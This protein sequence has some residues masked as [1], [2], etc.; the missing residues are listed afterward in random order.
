MK[1]MKELY[2][3][4]IEAEVFPAMG[5]TEPIAVALAAATACEGFGEEPLSVGITLNV[6][7]Y[8]NGLAVKI[9]NTDNERGNL[10][11]AVL[12]AFIGSAADK[13][14][15]LKNVTP[16]ILCK[17]KQFLKQKKGSVT[18][19]SEKTDFYVKAEII[20][21]GHMGT[22]I[23]EHGHT[24]VSFLRQD[25]CVRID[26]K[27]KAAPQHA[28]KEKLKSAKITD[29]IGLCGKLGPE[30]LTYIE[31]GVKMNR[32]ISLKGRS[33]R[34]VG[35]YLTDLLNKN[36]LQEDLFTSTKI[37]TAYAVDAR[38]DGMPYPVMSSG[39]S[40]NQGII[41]ILVPYNVGKHFNTEWETILRSIALSHMLNAYIKV[42]IG[43]LAPI[44]G[45]AISAGVGAA[46]AIAYQQTGGDLKAITLSINNLISD[47]GG[48]ICDGAKSGCALK[49]ISSADSAIR[50]A[51]MGINHYGI[52][53]Q[54][55]FIGQTAEETIANLTK[56]SNMGMAAVDHTI[57]D[58][59][60]DKQARRKVTFSI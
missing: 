39:G 48:M 36:Y 34:K 60:L 22:C 23:I 19:D 24:A 21:P 40:G 3:E 49:V 45:C 33:L 15:I 2:H 41:A 52:E 37:L 30:E 27:V 38:M 58:I 26:R 43:E 9:P 53:E 59:M 7:T 16:E 50:S 55:G 18:V 11:A 6:S 1:G 20:T 8:K 47:L 13:M 29:M 56:I 32:E 5:C 28:Y 25:D 17:A 42:F 14:E 46:A 10:I 31:K 12:G 35:L 57:V 54:E 51:Y 44:C 4:I